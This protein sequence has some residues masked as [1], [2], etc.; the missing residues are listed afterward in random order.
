MIYFPTFPILFLCFQWV[1]LVEDSSRKLKDRK[2][3]KS[4]TF[5]SLAS[6]LEVN[7]LYS[8]IKGHT[9]VRYT[10]PILKVSFYLNCV[11]NIHSSHLFKCW[12]FPLT[13]LRNLLKSLVLNAFNNQVWAQH[14][15]PNKTTDK[16]PITRLPVTLASIFP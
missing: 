16:P 3:M 5:I 15:F 9:L 6:P 14:L 8:F 11:L 13:M 1:W 12:W 7:T 10:S 2:K 4:G